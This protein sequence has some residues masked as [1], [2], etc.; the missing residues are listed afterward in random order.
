MTIAIEFTIN[1]ILLNQESLQKKNKY[2]CPICFEFIYK[3]P[4]YQC[5][6]GHHACQQC[7]EK[8]LEK[9]CTFKFESCR[10]DGC[11]K[12]LR[13]HSLKEHE[14]QC[15]FKLIECIYCERDD[16]IKME[17]NDHYDQCPKVSIKCP[18]GCSNHI[19]RQSMDYHVV[20]DCDNTLVPCKYYDQ[21]CKALMKRSELLNHLENVNHQI[22]MCELIEKLSSS[23]YQSKESYNE[24]LSKLRDLPMAIEKYTDGCLKKYHLPVAVEFCTHGYKNKWIIS[25]YSNV[26]KSKINTQLISSPRFSILQRIFQVSLYPKGCRNSNK[27]HISVF[28]RFNDE[29]PKS[30]KVEFSFTLINVLDK[31]KSVTKKEEKVLDGTDGWGWERYA[32]IDLLNKENG[33]LSN[34]DKLT[35]EIYVKLLNDEIEPLES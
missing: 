35:I 12:I 9:K 14:N 4:I 33:W 7:W 1:D 15:G 26:S 17:L 10:H 27:D 18:L 29:A 32:P 25:N 28:L 30:I 31:S 8:S 11:D 3:K 6:S 24:L 19:E 2:T 23:I 16:I 21:G 34:D 22:Y 20:N 13:L 5:K